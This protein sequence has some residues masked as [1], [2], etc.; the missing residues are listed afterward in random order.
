MLELY[1]MKKGNNQIVIKP[2]P[3][4]RSK[5]IMIINKRF[6]IF[7]HDFSEFDSRHKCFLA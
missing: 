4:V 1:Q 6:Q 2:F 7:E 5:R 3:I